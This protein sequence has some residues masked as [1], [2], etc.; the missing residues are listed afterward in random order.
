L[1]CQAQ[2]AISRAEFSNSNLP[3]IKSDYK[4]VY[5]WLLNVTTQPIQPPEIRQGD[6]KYTREEGIS[7]PFPKYTSKYNLYWPP[8]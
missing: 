5:G 2:D 3:F 8:H 4:R 1:S 7:N 6:R